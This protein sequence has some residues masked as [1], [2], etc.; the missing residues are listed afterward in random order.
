VVEKEDRERRGRNRSR[1]KGRSRRRR[2]RMKREMRMGY[3]V[4]HLMKTFFVIV[5]AIIGT[6][7]DDCGTNLVEFFM[8]YNPEVIK[9]RA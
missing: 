4:W 2:E 8:K 1:E 5:F 7:F 6:K 9:H 3:V